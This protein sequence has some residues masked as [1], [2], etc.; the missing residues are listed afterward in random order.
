MSAVFAHS[1][2]LGTDTIEWKGLLKLQQDQ[3]WLF[4]YLEVTVKRHTI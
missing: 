2:G 4:F 3:K 1:T